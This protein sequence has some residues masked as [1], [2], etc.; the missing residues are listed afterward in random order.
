MKESILKHLEATSCGSITVR[1]SNGWFTAKLT[2]SYTFEGH[3]YSRDVKN[4]TIGVNK[5]ID[6][7]CGATDISAKCEEMWGFGWSTIF[8]L[9]FDTPVT[10]CYEIWGTTLSPHYKEVKC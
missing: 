10:K 9:H 8:N 2:I 6:I 4:I 5:T 3:T 7:P 1:N